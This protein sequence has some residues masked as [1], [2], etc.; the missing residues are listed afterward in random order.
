MGMI[1]NH[2]LME[3]QQLSGALSMP[4]TE[5][6]IFPLQPITLGD[7][8]SNKKKTGSLRICH[9]NEFSTKFLL[10]TKNLWLVMLQNVKLAGLHYKVCKNY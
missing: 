7:Q 8:L 5:F 1:T 3:D 9:R 2:Q 4:G 6:L 10:N